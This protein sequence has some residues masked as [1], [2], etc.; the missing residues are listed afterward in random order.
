VASWNVRS[1]NEAGAMKNL[2][3]ELK[4]YGVD[5]RNKEVKHGERRLKTDENG[6]EQ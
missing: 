3:G 2:I 6:Q 5:L 4:R 1:L